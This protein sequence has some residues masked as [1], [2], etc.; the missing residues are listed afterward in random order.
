M[1]NSFERLSYSQ[2]TANFSAN[3][4]RIFPGR[5]KGKARL[6]PYA[7]PEITPEAHFTDN[8]KFF[9][10]GNCYGRQ[11][12]RALKIAGCETTSTPDDLSLPGTVLQQ[13]QRYNVYH[14]DVA[15]NEIAWAIDPN[16][17]SSDDAFVIVDDEW[18]DMQI[19]FSFAHPKDEAR[20]HRKTFNAAYKK[21]KDADVVIITTGGI[22]VW[23]DVETKLYLNTMP[24]KRIVEIYPDRF[25]LHRFDLEK[26]EASLQRTI[27]TILDNT[28]V[29]PVVFITAS[30]VFQPTVF[31]RNDSL[32]EQSYARSCQRVAAERVCADYDNVEYLPGLEFTDLSDRKFGF[33]DFSYNHTHSC[34]S[35]RLTAEMLEKY[36]GPSAGQRTL[37]AVGHAEALCLAEDFDPAIEVCKNALKEGI[38]SNVHFDI[39]YLQALSRA[40]RGVEACTWVMTRAPLTLPEDHALFLRTA[41]VVIQNYASQATLGQFIDIVETWD[42]NEDAVAAALENLNSAR[43]TGKA[44]TGGAD[45]GYVEEVA[46]LFAEKDFDKMIERCDALFIMDCDPKAKSA[47]L[48]YLDKTFYLRGGRKMID[49]LIIAVGEDPNIE[50]I[51]KIKLAQVARGAKNLDQIN[52]VLKLSDKMKDI[53]GFENFLRIME[54]ARAQAIEAAT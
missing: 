52:Q 41:R 11:I 7:K 29:S 2:V 23:F 45:R 25:E 13:Y 40:Y 4:L 53:P 39:N 46:G 49:Y 35:N 12:E 43:K 32:I 9:I 3:K 37:H 36:Q 5:N 51:W 20:A 50:I 1:T 21:V 34:M 22:E 27:E 42:K 48:R 14:Q 54:N 24:N 31:T 6:Y 28:A 18:A 30:P 33:S 19:N 10:A 26:C 38:N 17:Q 44:N 16:A 15:T 47:T 8:S